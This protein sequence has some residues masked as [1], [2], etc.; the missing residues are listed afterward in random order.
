MTRRPHL[1]R[2]LVTVIALAW[3]A[4]LSLHQPHFYPTGLFVDLPGGHW[5]GIE[6]RPTFGPFCDTT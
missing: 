5:C 6:I 3:L 2:L 1:T 4:L